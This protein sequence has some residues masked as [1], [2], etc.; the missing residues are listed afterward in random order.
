L[1]CPL[2]GLRTEAWVTLPPDG[3]KCRSNCFLLPLAKNEL[4]AEGKGPGEE[5][6]GEIWLGFII[7]PIILDI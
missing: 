4:A 2:G 1:H 6:E 3:S 7:S 5:E